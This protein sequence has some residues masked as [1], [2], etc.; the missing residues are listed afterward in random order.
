VNAAAPASPGAGAGPAV[1]PGP[2][3][4]PTDS[5][6]EQRQQGFRNAFAN[7]ILI[8]A[9]LGMLLGT[10][11]AV[12]PFRADGREFMAPREVFMALVP[13]F[14]TWVGTLLA[15]YFSR[16]SLD[17]ANASIKTLLNRLTPEQQLSGT[18]VSKVWVPRHQIRAFVMGPGRSETSVKLGELC[19]EL[20]NNRVSRLPVLNEAGA[21]LFVIHRST[22]NAFLADRYLSGASADP[23]DGTAPPPNALDMTLQDFLGHKDGDRT[24]RD[25]V[26]ALA[27]VRL[28]ASLAEAKARMN[29]T[30]N[31]QDVVVTKTGLPSEPVEGWLTNSDIARA[32]DL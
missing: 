1:A 12:V 26:S 15:F 19:A 28:D 29:A 22:L 20:S 6:F 25:Q 18:A 5:A 10:V 21:M 30:P 23:G 13:L 8:F 32:V 24:I 4:A 9:A 14:G 31:A 2:A 17:T 7:K 27:F 11:L 3:A 16:E